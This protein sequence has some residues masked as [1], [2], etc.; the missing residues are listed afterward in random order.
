MLLKDFITTV[1]GNK[2]Y[3]DPTD[4]AMCPRLSSQKVW[5]PDTTKLIMGLIKKGDVVIDVGANIG[6]YT[7]LFASLGKKIVAIE[8]DPYTFSLLKKNVQVNNYGNIELIEGAAT[9]YAGEC[10]LY[11]SNTNKSNNSIYDPRNNN[12]TISVPAVK[13]DDKVKGRVDFIKIDVEGAEFKVILGAL[14][15]LK[16]NNRLKI[17]SEFYPKGIKM[18]GMNPEEYLSVLE[19]S[20]FKFYDINQKRLTSK[21]ELVREYSADS[22]RITNLLCEK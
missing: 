3:L 16:S 19:S 10:R 18:N 17:L 22:D 13:L 14:N 15:I 11:L 6:Y 8:P 21:A 4:E 7:L 12:R 5:E 20:G 1:H 2:M 9:D